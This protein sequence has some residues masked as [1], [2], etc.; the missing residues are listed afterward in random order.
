MM[1]TL[2]CSARAAQLFENSTLLPW[3]HATSR[4]CRRVAPRSIGTARCAMSEC[5]CSAA[6]Q[7]RRHPGLRAP[8]SLKAQALMADAEVEVIEV[9][10]SPAHPKQDVCELHARADLW[11]LGPGLYPKA[12]AP[13]PPHQAFC[14]CRLRGRQSISDAGTREKPGGDAAY[15]RGMPLHQA[16]RVMG[17]QARAAAVL[18]GARAE[19]LINAGKDPLYRLAR[20][21]DAVGASVGGGSIGADGQSVGVANPGTRAQRDDGQHQESVGHQ[22]ASIRYCEFWASNCRT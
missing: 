14:G 13:R 20:A 11:D 17:S 3:R 8:A 9:R 5:N 4:V 2:P 15:L 16:A 21:W 18:N 7:T 1:Q 6:R 12:K 10:I 22:P 19:D